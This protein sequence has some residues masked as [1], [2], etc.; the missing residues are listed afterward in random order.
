[1]GSFPVDIDLRFNQASA[2]KAYADFTAKAKAMM[3]DVESGVAGASQKLEKLKQE[4]A[5]N[6][7]STQTRAGRQIESSIRSLERQAETAGKTYSQQLLV[8]QEK[9][10]KALGDDEAA[11]KRVT[12][13][14]QKLIQVE[15]EQERKRQAGPGTGSLLFRGARDIFEGRMSY[16]VMDLGRAAY[17]AIGGGAVAG[18]GGAGAAAAG[19]SATTLAVGGLTVALLGV[20][21]AGF[22]AA[23]SLGEY[24]TQVR[25]VELRTGLSAREVGQFGFAAKVVGQ[26]IS[27]AERMMR[28]LSQAAD[29]TSTDG[30]K[31]R[32]TFERLHITLVDNMTGAMKPTSQMLQEIGGALAKLPAGVERDTAAMAMFKRV[33]VEAIP[34]ITQLAENLKTAKEEGFGPSEEEI[35]RWQQYQKTIT[36]VETHWEEFKRSAMEPIAV[37]FNV[38]VK[39]LGKTYD[40]LTLVPDL[41]DQMMFGGSPTPADIEMKE[42]GGYGYGASE[43][44]AG[45]A[46]EARAIKLNDQLVTVGRATE[47]RRN[48]V[49]AEKELETL[50]SSLKLGVMPFIN[51]PTLD[52]INAKKSEIAGIKASIEAENQLKADQKT[53]T[54]DLRKAHED[55]LRKPLSGFE[56]PA[57]I[58]L[59]RRLEMRS[60][61]PGQA[62]EFTGIFAPQ[63]A[64]QRAEQADKLQRQM[65]EVEETI[66]RE[67]FHATL[68]GVQPVDIRELG[69][70][71]VTRADVQSDINEQYRQRLDIAKQIRTMEEDL[72]NKRKIDARDLVGLAQQQR[73]LTVTA[74]K[75]EVSQIEAAIAKKKEEYDLAKKEHEEERRHA[76]TM[77]KIQ[78]ADQEEGIKHQADLAR[79]RADLRFKGDNP[80]ESIAAEYKIATE[81]AAQL[82]QLEMQ[83]IALHETGYKAEEDAAIALHKLHREDE[84]AREEAQFKLAK[85]Q[86]E[87]LDNL[88][89]KI[90]PLYQTLF[91]D[92]KNFGKQLRSTVT[93]AALHPIVSGLSE[94]T[95]RAIYPTIYGATGTGGLAGIFGGGNRLN[96][97]TLLPDRSVPVTIV[98][99]RGGG[100]SI[101]STSGYSSGGETYI[102]G[103]G[104]I[105]GFTLPFGFGPG[106][107]AGFAPGSLGLS[108]GGVSTAR[109]AAGPGGVY[110]GGGGGIP[111][112]TIPTLGPGGTAGFAPGPLGI[113]GTAQRGPLAGIF[114]SLGGMFGGS[115]GGTGG[116][117]KIGENVSDYGG[118]F[119]DDSTLSESIKSLSTGPFAGTAAGPGA[120][121]IGMMLASAGIFGQQRGTAA[122]VVEAAGGGFLVGGPIGAAVGGLIGL[123]EMAAGVESPRHEVQRLAKSIYHIS[124]NNSTADQI[125]AM[126][127][128]SYGGNVATA[129]RSPQ[130]RQMLGLY[131]AGTGQGGVFAHGVDQPHGA[132]L[133]ES[134][135]SLYQAPTYEYGLPF[136]QRSSLP[137]YG[138]LSS[139]VVG[140]PGAPGIGIPSTYNL[141]LNVGGADAAKFMVGQVV[142]PEVVESQY[143][144]AMNSSSGRVGQALMMSAPGSIAG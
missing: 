134:G 140:P 39:M 72:I 131:A 127:N 75:E 141:S 123:G 88:K 117:G 17:G 53:I 135:G 22:K 114:K 133:V 130:V 21:A 92:P 113:G 33:G 36:D 104:G 46:G 71:G 32:K 143:S 19:I 108:P 13:A 73:D 94:M 96:D 66:G 84:A 103:G 77:S 70:G 60:I 24:S 29:D 81:E 43:S 91:T 34:F 45:H 125:V 105:P 16:G 79:R 27:I 144:T 14:F 119:G 40:A 61:T 106:G 120:G 111:G 49:L 59:R 26:D 102:G 116:F 85:M 52:K 56:L 82:Y 132:S 109:A 112:F 5:R 42:T 31:A 80:A 28:G 3:K 57:E 9:W 4:F 35:G 93:E 142:S 55:A 139:Q 98:N 137:V 74:G 8:R 20:E 118:A 97:L 86:Q 10:I 2:L 68:G 11:I 76:E 99:N 54:E 65:L 67:K 69:Q 64:Q 100:T 50:Q 128:Q 89:S 122:G 48:L 15:Q 58:E 7:I 107:T 90:E 6:M 124:V 23:K 78:L 38:T 47:E 37:V 101:F 25:D 44:R 41:A 136:T 95:A 62:R 63:I 51:Q 138:G 30:E 83:R 12:A 110:I 126:A 115:P 18:A 129:M 1:M 87:Q 121:A